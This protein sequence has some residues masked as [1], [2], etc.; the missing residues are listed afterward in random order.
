MPTIE[1]NTKEKTNVELVEKDQLDISLSMREKRRVSIEEKEV[2]VETKHRP[3]H[4]I[5]IEE[6]DG[7][8]T[9]EKAYDM[10]EQAIK[11]A[12]EALNNAKGASLEKYTVEE[13]KALRDSGQLEHKMYCVYVKGR[14]TYIYISHTLI[15]K[16]ADEGQAVTSSKFPYIFPIIFS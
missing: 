13:Y 1:I 12:N 15:A 8:T 4:H 11:A 14:L 3:K 7:K 6:W 10:A 5:T 2:D 9:A 16:R